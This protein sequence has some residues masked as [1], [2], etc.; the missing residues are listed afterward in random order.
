MLHDLA[1][2]ATEKDCVECRLA[3]VI[4]EYYELQCC[5]VCVCVS[6]IHMLPISM[7]NYR[8]FAILID[9]EFLAATQYKFR[10]HQTN[11]EICFEACL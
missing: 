10:M 4:T 3:G 9:L 1:R 11:V 8:G 7:L 5:C 6:S 2:V